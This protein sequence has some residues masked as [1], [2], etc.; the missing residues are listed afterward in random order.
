MNIYQILI[1]W[2]LVVI[3]LDLENG[4]RGTFTRNSDDQFQMLIAGGVVPDNGK[5]VRNIVSIRTLHYIQFYGD[6]HFCTGVILSSQTVLTAAHCVTDRH[7]SIMNPRGLLV[8]FGAVGRLD[9]YGKDDSR[10]ITQIAVH[11]RYQRYLKYD[12]ALLRLADR[13]PGNTRHV[14][15]IMTRKWASF[16]VG[17]LCITM[18]WG[19]LYPHGPYANELMYLEVAVRDHDFCNGMENYDSE[20]SICAEPKDEGQVC[21][22][23]LGSPII[24]S[25]YFTGI[26]GGAQKC[27]GIKALKFV[28]YSKVEAWVDK[29]VRM[30]SGSS[31]TWL[32]FYLLLFT[33]YA[34]RVT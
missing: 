9:K 25:T 21:P 32:S 7:K 3:R 6:N 34:L 8:V 15:P 23:D 20:S 28:N 30:F 10:R 1:V 14:K 5:F 19:Q 29:T 31:N 16:Y 2:L 22:G 27:E 24:C 33:L 26:I 12:V 13:I 18:G 17:M 4:E 11:P